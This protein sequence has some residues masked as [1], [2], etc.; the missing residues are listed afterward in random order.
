MIS[1][2]PLGSFFPC[3][4]EQHLFTTKEVHSLTLLCQRSPTVFILS[5]F[6]YV[7]WSQLALFLVVLCYLHSWLVMRWFSPWFNS[8][9]SPYVKVTDHTPGAHCK[10]VSIFLQH[11]QAKH[12]LN[13]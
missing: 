10:V 9:L 5:H 11:G 4:E 8:M 1:E 13:L 6:L 3:S 7:F 12:F 2:L